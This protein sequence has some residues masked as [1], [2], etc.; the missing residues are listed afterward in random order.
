MS[1][2]TCFIIS[3]TSTPDGQENDRVSGDLLSGGNVEEF[4]WAPDNSGIGYIADQE[5][6][7]V[8]DLFG[9]SPDGDG[10]VVLSGSFSDA[11]DG[12]VLFF[13]W[14]PLDK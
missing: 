6:D 10:T 12:D 1:F 13:E 7:G 9:F 8:F 14:V 11:D 3:G 2:R 4:A 5:S